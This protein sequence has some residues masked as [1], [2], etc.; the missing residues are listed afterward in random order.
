MTAKAQATKAK[1]IKWDYIKQKTFF[2]AEE[3]I[4]TMKRQPTEWEK[5]FANHL[6]DKALIS[7]ILITFL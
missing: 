5:I 7:K 2:I 6:S 4:S 3:T 1:I